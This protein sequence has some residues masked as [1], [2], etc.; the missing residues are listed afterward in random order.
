MTVTLADIQAAR[1][2]Q[3]NIINDT[4]MLPDEALPPDLGVRTFRNAE[5]LQRSG[6]IK[7]RGAYNKI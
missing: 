3:S 6:S 4:P 5:S 1:L 7:I 2:V